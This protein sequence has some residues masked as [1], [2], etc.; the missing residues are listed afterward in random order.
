MSERRIH[1]RRT[2]E[3]EEDRRK[4]PRFTDNE[5]NKSMGQTQFWLRILYSVSIIVALFEVAWSLNKGLENITQG[6]FF[7]VV[8]IILATMLWRGVYLIKTFLTNHSVT[9]L[10]RVQ[11]QYTLIFAYISVLAVIFYIVTFLY[12]V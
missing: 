1:H 3:E 11:E 4:I 8:F 2:E 6:V 5:M 9:N 7:G 10:R 12:R